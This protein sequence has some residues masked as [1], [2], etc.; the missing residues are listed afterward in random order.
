MQFFT[1]DRQPFAACAQRNFPIAPLLLLRLFAPQQRFV[2][3]GKA[4]SPELRHGIRFYPDHI[5]QNPIAQIQQNR[6]DAVNIVVGTDHP[7]GARVF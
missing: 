1:V 2:G 3:I 5:V 4:D 7:D 6:A